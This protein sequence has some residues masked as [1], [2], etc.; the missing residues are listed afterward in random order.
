MSVMMLLLIYHNTNNVKVSHLT[1]DCYNLLVTVYQKPQLLPSACRLL[2][3]RYN[4]S[5][6]LRP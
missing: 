6:F 2:S 5:R 3:S 1:S 4:V